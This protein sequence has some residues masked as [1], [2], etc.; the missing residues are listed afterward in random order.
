MSKVLNRSRLEGLFKAN[1][2]LKENIDEIGDFLE[3]NEKGKKLPEYY[4]KV[5]DMLKGE[6][7]KM[8]EELTSQ[9][10][11]IGLMK[12]II[13]TQQSYAKVESVTEE[14]DLASVVEDALTIQK[15]TILKYEV[16][17]KKNFAEVEMVMA[18]R[19]KGRAYNAELYKECCRG[20]VRE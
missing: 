14:I 19:S 1:D 11:H 2:M 17:V 20:D 6:H 15:G 8:E 5:G 13:S 4:F 3:N 12:D 16:E 9:I 7:E 18:N 10:K